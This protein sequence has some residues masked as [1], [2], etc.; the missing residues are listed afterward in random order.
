MARH[1][2]ACADCEAAVNSL[3][4]IS[5][6]VVA[7]IRDSGVG[8]N[9][10]KVDSV[11]IDG[12]P[13]PERLGDF[14]IIR[15]IGRGGMGFVYEAEQ[16][17]LGRRVALKVLPRHALLE[18]ESRRAV[19]PRVPPVAGLHHTNIVQM[20]GTGEH[21]GLHYFVMQLIRGVGLDRV[22]GELKQT[23]KPTPE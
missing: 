10:L 18:P 19:P 13:V 2:D 5:D 23:R 22:M 12:P 3:E 8:T 4:C 11:A 15:E 9:G 20:F 16:V 14:R 7:A 17:S 1:L 21:D 6:P